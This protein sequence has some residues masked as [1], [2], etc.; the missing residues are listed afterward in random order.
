[1]RSIHQALRTP[2]EKL[3][4]RRLE[5]VTVA[6]V[7]SGVDA[8]HPDLAGRV[9]EAWRIVTGKDG[10]KA[11][12][13]RRSRNND[14]FGHGT[15]V[16]GIIAQIAPNARIVDVRV[17]DEH[18]AA[19]GE[20]LL[21]GFRLAIERDARL[22][23]LSLACRAA[24]AAP[25][26]AMCEQAY[27]RNQIVIAAKRNMPLQDDGFPARLSSCIGVDAAALASPYVLRFLRWPPV[28]FA[29]RGDRVVTPAAG[30][31][32]TSMT[33]TSFATPTVTGLCALLVGAYPDLRLFEIK[34][35]LKDL[36]EPA[37]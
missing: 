11:D 15:G 36:A 31:G 9:D 8:T 4:A 5:P 10:A 28:E 13:G 32:Y 17:L 14:V 23:N 16:A 25:L 7:D 29:A 12:R 21:K 1:M 33:G 26:Q 20:A 6:V 18:N 22:I 35:V 19:T 24:Y 37:G 27:E 30:G 34:T 3:R 2:P